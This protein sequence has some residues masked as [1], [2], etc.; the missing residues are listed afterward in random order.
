MG[1][2][3]S[4]FGKTGQFSKARRMRLTA[5]KLAESLLDVHDPVTFMKINKLLN[6]ENAMDHITSEELIRKREKL[7]FDQ[8]NFLGQRTT[9]ARPPTE[10]HPSILETM[11]FLAADLKKAKHKAKAIELRR[12]LLT[13]QKV[14][15]SPANRETL[16]NMKRLTLMLTDKARSHVA[17]AQEGLKLFE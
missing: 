5:A 15:L 3:A 14:S 17:Q 13:A 2:L 6:C 4:L 8:R 10:I 7:L 9:P 1:K 16:R 12:E 11:S